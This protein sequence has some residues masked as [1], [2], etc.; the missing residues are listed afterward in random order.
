M[1]IDSDKAEIDTAPLPAAPPS[2]YGSLREAFNEAAQPELDDDETATSDFVVPRAANDDV[3]GVEYDRG[4]GTPVIGRLIDTQVASDWEGHAVI[5]LRANPNANEVWAEA[6][7]RGELRPDGRPVT[8]PGW[9]PELNKGWIDSIIE[10]RAIVY[11]GSEP[12]G[13]NLLSKDHEHASVF[14]TEISQLQD[15]GYQR[16]DNYLVPGELV[17]A[18]A[19]NHGDATGEE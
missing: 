4:E 17:E 14:A 15:A 9:S 5:D 12:T 18:F 7:E 13:D 2:E 10:D 19:G 8:E 16:A 11:L 3:A 6:H 1:A